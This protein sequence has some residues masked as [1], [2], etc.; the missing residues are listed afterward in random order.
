[1]CVHV[2]VHVCVCVCMCVCVH[3]C[4]DWS[5]TRDELGDVLFVANEQSKAGWLIKTPSCPSPEKQVAVW[6]AWKTIN[7]T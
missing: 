4:S 3:V 6:L 7:P 2:C 1:M 5:Y